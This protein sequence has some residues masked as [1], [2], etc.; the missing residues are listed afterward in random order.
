MNYSNA[1]A[2]SLLFFRQDWLQLFIA[3]SGCGLLCTLLHS[4]P[5]RTAPA[6][7]CCCMSVV[8][9]MGGLKNLKNLCQVLTVCTSVVNSVLLT[10]VTWIQHEVFQ[11]ENFWVFWWH[12][13]CWEINLS[14]VWKLAKKQVNKNTYETWF[15]F[16]LQSSI[17]LII[18]TI[19]IY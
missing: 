2:L 14:N 17:S 4:Q 10:G 18:L 8:T 6:S 11:C 16:S 7:C 3:L 1:I 5:S 15:F 12:F 9:E 13:L 19:I